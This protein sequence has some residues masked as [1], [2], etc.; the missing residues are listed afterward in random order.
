MSS[1]VYILEQLWRWVATT[2]I[3]VAALI[4][5]A[6][7]VPRAGRLA[8]HI[9]EEKVTANQDEEGSK[10]SLAIAGMMIYIAQIIAYF[11]IL[12][13]LLSRLGLSMTGAAIPATV[14][15][16]ALGFGAQGIIADFVAGFFL[17]SEKHYGVGDWVR[18]EGSG[19][20]T[21]G[22]VIAMTMRATTIRTLAQETVTIPNSAAKLCINTSNFFSR[23]VVVI[24]VPLRGSTSADSAVRRTERAARTAIS[25]PVIAMDILGDLE[26]QPAT[27]VNPPTT[28]GMP[29]TM[30][31]RVMVQVNPGAQ[32][33]TERAIRMAIL[34]EFWDEYGSATTAG[35][36][37]LDHIEEPE[38]EEPVT[39]QIPT[40]SLQKMAS[41]SESDP[42][43]PEQANVD[44]SDPA[45]PVKEEE[46]ERVPPKRGLEKWITLNGRMRPSTGWLLIAIVLLGV[47]RV[48]TLSGQDANGQRVSGPWA[49][50]APVA[51]SS[52]IAPSPAPESKAPESPTTVE[53]TPNQQEP[54][55]TIQRTEPTAPQ[56][57]Q[58]Y[59][60]TRTSTPATTSN[61]T[62][63]MSTPQQKTQPL[64]APHPAASSTA[65]PVN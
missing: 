47:A 4:V 62:G 7:L 61:G 8:E 64:S 40:R 56:R 50:P 52:S 31:M 27:E 28:V 1:L 24:P 6:F 48:M 34:D 59:P 54:T 22:T 18:F 63:D 26:M 5:V 29:W 44:G 17:L 55:T 19:V 23:A 60:T 41:Q 21:E 13:A 12:V 3:A 2:G 45:V 32:W 16:A 20:K 53:T 39:T 30:D 36:Q 33:K 25:K 65:D 35:G 49:P 43:P 15:S 57:Q 11:I 38:E 14:V 37:L 10:S 46:P 51:T 58:N 42:V 9:I